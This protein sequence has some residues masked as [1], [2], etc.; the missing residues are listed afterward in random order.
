M[1]VLMV[2]G[3]AFAGAAAHSVATAKNWGQPVGGLEMSV[4]RESNACGLNG[5]RQFQVEL[6]NAGRGELQLDIGEITPLKKYSDKI[7]FLLTDSQGKSREIG[8]PMLGGIAGTRCC[9]ACP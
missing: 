3:L 2:C 7:R 1:H 9:F 5:N 8:F 6:R 4:F